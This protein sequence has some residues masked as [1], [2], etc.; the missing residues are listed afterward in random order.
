M[1]KLNFVDDELA[2][3]SLSVIEGEVSYTEEVNKKNVRIP[4]GGAYRVPT[5]KFH[6]VE[7]ISSF[8]A[9]YMYTFVNRTEQLLK[10]NR[11]VFYK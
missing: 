6:E 1:K 8:P 2:N 11:S 5:G 3:V 4:K 7:V 10:T 9:Y